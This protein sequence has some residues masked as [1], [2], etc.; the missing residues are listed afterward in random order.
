[1]AVL[2]VSTGTR[3]VRKAL[4]ADA[5]NGHRERTTTVQPHE[6]DVAHRFARSPNELKTRVDSRAFVLRGAAFV[7]MVQAAD[8]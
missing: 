3:S 7:Q 6:A 5:C 4:V 1:M 2:S 8:L